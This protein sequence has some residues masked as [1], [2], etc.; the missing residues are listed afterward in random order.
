MAS[1]SSAKKRKSKV[2]FDSSKFVSEE[3]QIRYHDSV[4]NRSLIAERGLIP[5][6][7]GFPGI[8]SII[9][10]RGGVSF[11]HSLSLLLFLL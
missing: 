7:T 1:S 5:T 11:V 6:S 4:S 8:W 2:V 10:Q 3:A 9:R